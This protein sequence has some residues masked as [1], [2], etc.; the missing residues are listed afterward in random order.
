VFP[1]SARVNRRCCWIRAVRLL[2]LVHRS[3]HIRMMPGKRSKGNPDPSRQVEFAGGNGTA[4]AGRDDRAGLPRSVG[5]GRWPYA[6]VGCDF[7]R[8]TGRCNSDGRAVAVRADE[9]HR[10]TL[11]AH[12]NSLP[13]NR[14][15]VNRRHAFSLAGGRQRQRLRGRLEPAEFGRPH[16]GRRTRNPVALTAGFLHFS[17]FPDTITPCK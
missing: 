10:A 6:A 9:K 1:A 16:E 2:K 7:V 17:A 15:A 5:V 14:F 8:G 4:A 13:E 3:A 12:A 11:F